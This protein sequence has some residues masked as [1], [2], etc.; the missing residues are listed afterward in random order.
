MVEGPNLLRKEQDQ[1]NRSYI[2]Q[3]MK[4]LFIKLD[5]PPFESIEGARETILEEIEQDPSLKDY[6]DPMIDDICQ[7]IKAE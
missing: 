1:R 5:L 6:I 2:T 3:V 4:R 7:D